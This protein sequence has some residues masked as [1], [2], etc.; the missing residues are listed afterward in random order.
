[1]ESMN[2]SAED[3]AREI[4]RINNRGSGKPGSVRLRQNETDIIA[5]LIKEV[6]QLRAQLD[7][8]NEAVESEGNCYRPRSRKE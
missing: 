2:K 5:L 8:A 1:M 6:G 4:D 3:I 7:A